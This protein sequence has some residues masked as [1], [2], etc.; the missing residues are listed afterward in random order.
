MSENKLIHETLSGQTKELPRE[1]INVYSP[2]YK[3]FY[4][5]KFDTI[6]F[7]LKKEIRLNASIEKVEEKERLKRK[8]LFS[9]EKISE[10]YK[11]TI[12]KIETGHQYCCVWQCTIDEN[13]SEF[14]RKKLIKNST[15]R[16]VFL[17]KDLIDKVFNPLKKRINDFLN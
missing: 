10:K 7:G 8:S 4:M 2:G 17:D 3:F 14:Y 1:I 11:E 15:E 6:Q 13:S 12:W 9:K 16:G 5:G